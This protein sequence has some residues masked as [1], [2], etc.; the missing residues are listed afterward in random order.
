MSNLSERIKNLTPEQQELLRRRMNERAPTR[1]EV[2]VAPAAAAATLEP[3][4]TRRKVD[5]SIFF[6]S[7]DGTATIDDRY[8]FLLECVRFADRNG[9]SAVWTP[10]RHFQTF[11]GLYPN[12]SVLSAALAMI[13]E[14][15]QIRAGSLV[16]PLHNPV[17]VAEDWALVDNLSRGRVAISFATGWHEHDYVIAPG[18]YEERRELMFQNIQIVRRLWAGE[19][20]ELPGVGGKKTAVRTLPRPIQP[21]LPFWVTVTSRRTWQKAGE[22]GANVLT[23]LSSTLDDLRQQITTYRK[24]RLENGHDPRTGVVSLMLHTY[25]GTDLDE[26]RTRVREPLKNYLQSY[27]NQ[28]APMV[29]NGVTD[30]SSMEM[31]SLLDLVFEKYF[32][33]SSLLGTPAKCAAMVE[34][35]SAA[36]VNDVACLVDFGLDLETTLESLQ[37]LAD[38]RRSFVS[39]TAVLDSMRESSS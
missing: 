11:G 25:M 22:V 37:R 9:F 27:I 15:V 28:W 19:E 24:A 7:A 14:R 18:N 6:F 26:I 1:A 33:E 10:E 20:V 30:P 13:T 16:L 31:Q 5:F 21:E 17:R 36:G 35:V 4:S 2:R 12:P 29:G 38:L 39:Q 34:K 32:E 23:A 3:S 8:K